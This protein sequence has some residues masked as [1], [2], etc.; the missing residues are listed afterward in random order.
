MLIGLPDFHVR[1]VV[2]NIL[3]INE[4]GRAVGLLV[5]LFVCLFELYG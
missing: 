3:N 2:P 5:C 4:V 1:N